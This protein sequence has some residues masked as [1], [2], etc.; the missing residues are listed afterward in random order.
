M[1]VI[2]TA[3][4]H[5]GAKNSKLPKDKASL[6]RDEAIFNLKTFFEKIKDYDVVLISG[7]LFH[8]A[9]VA[10]KIVKAFF[11]SVNKF[12]KPVIYIEGNHDEKNILPEN[13]PN[14][15]INLSSLN[16]FSF[17]GV[18]F[19]SANSSMNLVKGETNILLLHGDID[20][21]QDNDYIDLSQFYD[22]HFDYIALGHIH[23]FKT[24]NLNNSL[25]AYPGSLFSNGFDECGEKGYIALE[26]E[27]NKITKFEYVIFPSR[28]YLICNCDITKLDNTFDIVNLIEHKLSVIGA[29]SKDII[30][31][32]I[33]GKVKED[34]E[35]SLALINDHFNGFFYFEVIDNTRIEI[36]LEKIKKEKLSFKYEFIKLVENSDLSEEDKNSIC[37]IGI[38]ALKGE[39]ISL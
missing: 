20:N 19:F 31:V 38:E 35:I 2:H 30:R 9:K 23:Q 3:D 28:K 26:I 8:S 4:L 24:I 27:N 16:Y 29:T 22:K 1:K 39:E 14:N 5:L 11:D 37:Q 13:L 18:N 25:V 10:N 17:G 34:D 12:E 21:S 15:F 32:V 33:S 7:D 36:D 6:M